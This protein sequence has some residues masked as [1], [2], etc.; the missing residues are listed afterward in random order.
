[1]SLLFLYV[2]KKQEIKKKK[3]TKRTKKEIDMMESNWLFGVWLS[4]LPAAVRV[5]L[6]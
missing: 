5:V 4:L 1:M 6:F 2:C 3:Q